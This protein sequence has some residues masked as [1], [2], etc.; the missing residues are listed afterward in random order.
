MKMYYVTDIDN[1]LNI[2]ALQ[3]ISCSSKSEFLYKKYP[4][5]GEN[6]VC[7]EVILN[8]T[9]NKKFLEYTKGIYYLTAGI[10]LEIRNFNILFFNQ[11]EMDNFKVIKDLY[12]EIKA[13]AF[14]C[15]V[16]KVG[17]N[18]KCEMVENILRL[19]QISNYELYKSNINDALKGFLCGFLY[20]NNYIKE[21]V[22]NNYNLGYKELSAIT[23]MISELRGQKLMDK[24]I[25]LKS[26]NFKKALEKKFYQQIKNLDK[27][28]LIFYCDDKKRLR[29][30]K[31]IIT[32]NE[33][34]MSLFEV[35]INNTIQNVSLLGTK[36]LVRNNINAIYEYILKNNIDNLYI[37]DIQKV[38]NRAN[39]LDFDI[40]INDIKSEFFKNLFIT[41]TKFENLKEFQL[42]LDEKKVNADFLA[43]SMFGL[44]KG[45]S[46]LP[47]S[48][49]IKSLYDS[50]LNNIF[51]G[52]VENIE[53]IYGDRDYNRRY[54]ENILYYYFNKIAFL[55]KNI[56]QE[57]IENKQFKITFN[58]KDG[59]KYHL[60]IDNKE[61]GKLLINYY[62]HIENNIYFDKKINRL[63]DA[64]NNFIR[65]SH[66]YFSYELRSGKVKKM[67]KDLQR[68]YYSIVIK[69]IYKIIE[70]VVYNGE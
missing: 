42:I 1:L 24:T 26:K 57:F 2:L 17:N 64:Y 68:Y 54:T 6:E 16:Q 34:E 37:E 49:V 5:L 32:L 39:D 8:K 47:N 67:C 10:N 69:D 60:V 15:Y 56:E 48:F 44:C 59:E 65:N 38:Y 27:K 36:Q 19:P 63:K 20:Y 61:I 7:I 40:S 58:K 12:Y 53:R 35:F 9:D 41:Y 28:E 43:H 18:L 51:L 31:N 13:A 30:N 52:G 55:L 50:I 62:P 70:R 33:F 21:F 11:K 66:Y 4:V 14:S 45:Y 29:V 22:V 3:Y 46:K 23:K 25:Y